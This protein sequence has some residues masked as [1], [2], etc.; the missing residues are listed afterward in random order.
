MP[1]PPGDNTLSRASQEP[2]RDPPLQAILFAALVVALFMHCGKPSPLTAEKVDAL[3]REKVFTVEPVFA[4]VPQKVSFGPPSPADDF[5]RKSVV[6]LLNLQRA[7]LLTVTMHPG[8]KGM[9]VYESKVT[10]KGFPILGTMPS[11][12]GP[13]FRGRICDKVFDG[14]RNF[15]RHPTDPTVGRAEI[16]WHYANPTPLYPL[17]ETKINKPLGRPFAT[18][19]SIHWDHEWKIDVIVA[20]TEE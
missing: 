16:A 5:D 19:V 2:R 20:K 18:I 15:V 13:A 1:A 12:R 6:T 14:I 9:T 10:G 17:F 11:Y 3:I 7:G 8:P 4:E